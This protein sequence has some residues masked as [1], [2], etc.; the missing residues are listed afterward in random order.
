MMYGARVSLL[1]GVLAQI[2]ILAIGVPIGAIAGYYGGQVD[3]ILMRLVD[4][5]YAIP[6]LLLVLMFVNWRG[7]G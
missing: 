6:Q 7:P 1:V 3:N 4:V 5:V 2:I